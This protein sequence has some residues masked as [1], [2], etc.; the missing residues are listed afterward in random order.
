MVEEIG[1]TE[2]GDLIEILHEQMDDLNYQVSVLNVHMTGEKL[3]F[4]NKPRTKSFE[5]LQN[6][7]IE[8]QKKTGF[9]VNA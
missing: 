4:N 5:E 3:I 6:E 1:T 9:F 2:E 8:T 7:A